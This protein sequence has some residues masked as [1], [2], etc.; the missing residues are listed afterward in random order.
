MSEAVF[1]S[2]PP[3]CVFDSNDLDR[4]PPVKHCASMAFAYLRVSCYII[5]GLEIGIL[6]F[7]EVFVA[8]SEDN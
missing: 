7:S 6:E 2:H 3:Q 4:F 8:V 5:K 1:I